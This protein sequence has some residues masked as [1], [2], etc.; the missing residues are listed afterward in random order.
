[1]RPQKGSTVR[2]NQCPERGWGFCR[3]TSGPVMSHMD[4][5]HEKEAY[6]LGSALFTQRGILTEMKEGREGGREA[7]ADSL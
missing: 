5:R 6:E 1:M 3:V 7:R 4:K 2:H